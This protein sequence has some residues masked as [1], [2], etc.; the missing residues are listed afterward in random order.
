MHL[1]FF[2]VHD[3]GQKFEDQSGISLKGIEEVPAEAESLLR[4]LAYEHINDAKP[5][6]LKAAVRDAGGQRI[7]RATIVAGY[8]GII[9][10]GLRSS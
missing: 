10:T 5:V 7:F 3:G 2:D 9:F 1:Y 4:L 8:G 6:V